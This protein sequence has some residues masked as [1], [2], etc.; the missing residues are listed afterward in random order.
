MPIQKK[1]TMK[2]MDKQVVHP[3]KVLEKFIK[4]YDLTVYRLAKE[5][6]IDASLLGKIIKGDRPISPFVSLCLGKLNR[7]RLYYTKEI[8]NG[9]S[10]LPKSDKFLS[11]ATDL[12]KWFRKTFKSPKLE[13]YED[14]IVSP[15][16]FQFQKNGGILL[17]N[18]EVSKS[19]L[20]S[21]KLYHTLVG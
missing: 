5:I 7:G 18:P 8:Y 15:S 2:K 17:V 19:A 11:M 12:F 1:A 16:A 14:F 3:G 4:D 20:E 9:N 13:G 21:E 6:K 10:S